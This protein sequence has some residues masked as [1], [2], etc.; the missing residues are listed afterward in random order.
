MPGTLEAFTANTVVQLADLERELA[1][2]RQRG[3][4]SVVEELE[5][6]L[7][8]VSA[9]VFDSGSNMIAA[10]SVSGP[11]YRFGPDRFPEV[12]KKTTAAAEVISR[13]LGW[14]ERDR[15]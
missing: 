4:A 6:G 10:L 1:G 9:P 11:A 14:V 2:V 12:A 3:W 15:G 8:A 5:I 13:R 7:N